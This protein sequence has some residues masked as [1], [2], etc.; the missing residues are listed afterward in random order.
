MKF[1]L[2]Y[3]LFIS[4]VYSGVDARIHARSLNVRQNTDSQIQTSFAQQGLCFSYL[5][6]GN[7]EKE[8]GPC[9]IWCEKQNQKEGKK[10]TG[11]GVRIRRNTHSCIKVDKNGLVA[12]NFY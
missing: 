1:S 10:S 7:K 9:K 5:K 11:Y 2:S 4:S 12:N 6:G 8:L 3:V